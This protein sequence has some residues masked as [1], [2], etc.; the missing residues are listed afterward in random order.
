MKIIDKIMKKRLMNDQSGIIGIFTLILG[1]AL[2]LG[3]F[4]F[5]VWLSQN[6]MSIAIPLLI[7]VVTVV[8]AKRLLFTGQVGRI[9]G[10]TLKKVK[11]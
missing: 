10:E 3:G 5:L 7:I 1:L 11:V 8:L 9:T 6:L 2:L 4:A